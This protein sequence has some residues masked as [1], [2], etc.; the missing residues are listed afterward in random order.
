MESINK[1]ISND[2]TYMSELTSTPIAR[3]HLVKYTI[4][5]GVNSSF[6][7]LRTRR[8][9]LNG[10]KGFAQITYSHLQVRKLCAH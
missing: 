7:S 2:I 9:T 10:M 5:A 4:G 8:T 3:Y 1:N 6:V